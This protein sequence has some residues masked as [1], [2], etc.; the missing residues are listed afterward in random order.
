MSLEPYQYL[1]HAASYYRRDF[2][3]RSIVGISVHSHFILIR[4]IAVGLCLLLLLLCFTL[5]EGAVSLQIHFQL[6]SL[7]FKVLTAISRSASRYPRVTVLW[8]LRILHRL[9]RL[10]HPSFPFQTRPSS[11]C[12]CLST[13]HSQF[14][15]T[16]ADF[17]H[18][19]SGVSVADVPSSTCKSLF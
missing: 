6:F 19:H 13:T 2:S 1:P 10:S 17:Q 15:T 14:S 18:R 11:C 8:C 5:L 3:F 9:P 16:P 12:H 7:P 4:L